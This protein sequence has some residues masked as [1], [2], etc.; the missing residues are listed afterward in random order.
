M[1]EPNQGMRRHKLMTAE[2]RKRI[3]GLYTQEGETDPIVQ[4]KFFCPY[5]NWT[6]YATEFCPHDERFFGW[7]EGMENEWGYFMLQ[8]LAEATQYKNFRVPAIE[9]DMHFTPCR[10]SECSSYEPPEET[11]ETQEVI[12]L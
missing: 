4:V 1:T 7:V 11:A 6:W 3:P 10:L 12:Y 9:R 5:S 8:E 2:I